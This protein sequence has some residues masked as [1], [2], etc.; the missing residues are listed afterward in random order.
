MK[1]GKRRSVVEPRN[2]GAWPSVVDVLND[3]EIGELI[4]EPKRVQAN[5]RDR[6]ALRPGKRDDQRERAIE[7]VGDRGSVFRLIARQDRRFPQQF[8][9]VLAYRRPGSNALFRLCRYNGPHRHPNKIERT[10]VTGCHRHIAT[11]RYQLAGWAE[12]AYAEADGRYTDLAGALTALFGDCAFTEQ[13]PPDEA[14]LAMR[15]R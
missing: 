14:Q 8:S 13:P 15:F 4:A 1:A 3:D 6:L 9:A 7:L 11:E 10:V 5:W 12:E 2:T